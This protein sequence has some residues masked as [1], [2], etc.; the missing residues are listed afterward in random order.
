MPI[1]RRD[2]LK[3]SGGALAVASVTAIAT[4]QA[5]AQPT[6]QQTAMVDD[7]YHLLNR[8]TWGVRADELAHARNIGY[9]AYL[10]EQLFPDSIDDSQTDDRMRRFALLNLN[11]VQVWRL[12]DVYSRVGPALIAG[13]ITRAV[14]SRRQLQERMTEFW[15]DHF[16]IP[17]DEL[18]GDLVEWHRETIRRHALGNFRDLLFQTAR[19]PAM[20]YYLDNYLNVAEHPN[21]NWARELMELHTLGVDGGYS[22]HDVREVARAFTGW[23]V[24]EMSDDGFYFDPS[25]H[26]TEEKVV[27]GHTLPA[28]R[29]IEDGLHVLSILAN[30]PMTARY[31]SAKLIRRF[32]SDAPPESLVE[33]TAQVWM[34]NDGEIRPVLRHLFLSDEFRASVGQKLRRPLEFFVAA[35]RSTGTEFTDFWRMYSAL[36][37]LAQ[38]PYGWNPPNGYPDVA[39]AWMNTSGLLARWNAAVLLTHGAASDTEEWGIR[40]A[41]YDRIDDPQTVAELVDQVAVAVYGENIL[42][43]AMTAEFIDFASDTQGAHTPVTARLLAR[44]YAT[45]YS[46]MLSAPIFQW[47]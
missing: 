10:E 39:G 3:W 38:I 46:L 41:L 14:H 21:E 13:M 1:S 17:A 20:L 11:R 12:A 7:V 9:H 33:S 44:K 35:V 23:T 18:A 28:G 25:V 2:F 22:E 40:S 42:S 24:S 27:L 43:P 5:W 19:T 6:A 30:H 31:I 36:E 37:A 32:V 34:E 47:R 4:P 26:D 16:N 8:I 29:G 15:L 45:L